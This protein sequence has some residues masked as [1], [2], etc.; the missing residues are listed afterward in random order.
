M[1]EMAVTRIRDASSRAVKPSEPIRHAEE[2]AAI[3]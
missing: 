3:L 1:L 2:L